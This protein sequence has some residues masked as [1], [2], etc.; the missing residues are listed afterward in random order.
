MVC[1]YCN[2]KTKIINS[3]FNNELAR[4]WRRHKCLKCQAIFTSYE[5]FDLN[6]SLKV[7]K[8]NTTLEPFDRTKLLLSIYKTVD[9]LKDPLKS[10]QIVLN[11][12]LRH[13][14]QLDTLPVVESN[15]I[16]KITATVLKR[17]DAAAAVVYLSYKNNLQLPQDIKNILKKS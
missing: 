16:N 14:Y 17:Y 11:S 13:I 8:R 1:L 3:R 5:D 2:S 10:S 15:T 6:Q 7:S 9:H 12:V 4:T